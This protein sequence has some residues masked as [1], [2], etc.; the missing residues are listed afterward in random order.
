MTDEFNVGDGLLL[1]GEN[2]ALVNQ[3]IH[4]VAG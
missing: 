2:K 4:S 3:H 1:L